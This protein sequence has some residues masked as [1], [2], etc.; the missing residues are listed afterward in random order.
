M[1]RRSFAIVLLLVLG[2]LVR[3]QTPA[4]ISA[5]LPVVDDKAEAKAKERRRQIVE[6]IG[7]EVQGLRLAENRAYALARS[8]SLICRDD[9]KAAEALFQRGVNELISA[10]MAAESEIR[11]RPSR[12]SQQLIRNIR[13]N[14]LTM[15]GTCDGELALDSLYRTRTP[16]ILR[17]LAEQPEPAGGRITDRNSNSSQTAQTELMLEQRLLGLAAQQNPEIAAK[18]LQDSI[19][20]GMSPDT[21]GLLKRLHAKDPETAASLARET[22]DRL[23]SVNFSP[24]VEDRN[25]VNLAAAI[26]NDHIRPVRAGSKD[27]RFDDASVRS[28][29]AKYIN[30]SIAHGSRFSAA[31]NLQQ[32]IRIAQSLSPGHVAALRRVE[33]DRRPPTMGPGPGAE[34]QRLISS[35]STPQQMIAGANRLSEGDKRQV[36]QSAAE[37]MASSGDYQAALG[38]LNQNFSGRALE[39]AV[40]ALSRRYADLLINQGKWDEAENLIDQMDDAVRR[41]ALTDLAKKAYAK[42]AAANKD[43]ALNALRKVRTLLAERPTDNDSTQNFVQLAIAYA[44]IDADEAFALME[45]T[46]PVLNDLADANAVVSAFRSDAQVRQGEYVLLPGPAYGFNVDVAAWRALLKADPERTSKLIDR[47][48]RQEIRIAVR[49]QIAIEPPPPPPAP[50]PVAR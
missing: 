21:L 2:G 18:V 36:Y 40:Q 38:F 5:K 11:S 44:P 25:E 24:D 13:P 46:I 35:R 22:M 30:Y 34:A 32:A 47:F 42:D 6:Q 14:V 4:Q 29:A 1:N 31:G 26:L 39:N 41:R 8:G 3:A 19:K 28:L 43:V 10:Q 17:D 15:I 27:L 7:A 37:R 33:R 9:K 20:K 12:L 23:L 50:R 49:F 48:A 16:G 45:S